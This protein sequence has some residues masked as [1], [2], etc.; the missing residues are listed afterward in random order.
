MQEERRMILKMIEDGKISAEEG[1]NLLNALKED[2]EK[3]E[4]EEPFKNTQEK[5]SEK[6][7]QSRAKKRTSSAWDYQ[8][9]EEKM[10]SF[11]TKFSEFVDDAVHR[12]KDFDL[13]FNFGPS[14]SVEHVFDH[15]D[16]FLKEANI[17]IE[18]GNV[19]L[20]PWEE[21]DI[22]IEC[23]VEVYRV[24]DSET[25]RKEFLREAAFSFSNG[26]LQFHVRK[27]SMKVNTIIYFPTENLDKLQLYTFNG[28][29]AGEHIPV[30]Q[31]TAKTINGKMSFD[32]IDAKETRLETMNG[33]IY[34][35]QLNT[36]E[37]ELKT[38]NGTVTIDGARGNM[39]IESVNGTIHFRLSEA[40]QSKAYMKTHMGSVHIAVPDGV[41]T[42]GEVKTS[43]GGI[44]CQLPNLSIIEEKKEYAQKR[45]TFLANKQGEGHFYIEAEATTGSVHIK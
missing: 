15:K 27:K 38:M 14:E 10:T 33:P 2:P 37:G 44:H 41:K 6:Q 21:K 42:E 40:S 35:R 22:R 29:M 5:T 34:V 25:A 11:A 13:D 26:K 16:V 24:K 3:Q 28:K 36:V 45:L 8:R 18:N 7:E 4:K 17:H 23:D 1:M 12:V 31:L 9:A 19:E 30:H 20:R 32:Q 39:N 43:V